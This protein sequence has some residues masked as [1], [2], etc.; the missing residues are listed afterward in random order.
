MIQGSRRVRHTVTFSSVSPRTTL[1]SA[2]RLVDSRHWLVSSEQV[3]QNRLI[4]SIGY[5]YSPLL[6][7]INQM[8]LIS[9]NYFQIIS[10]HVHVWLC[11]LAIEYQEH[12]LLKVSIYRGVCTILIIITLLSRGRPLHYIYSNHNMYT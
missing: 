2:Y 10:I 1:M 3:R 12:T 6:I 8:L 4:S 7:I 9:A 11:L 5:M